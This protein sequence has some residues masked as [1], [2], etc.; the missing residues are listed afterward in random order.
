MKNTSHRKEIIIQEAAERTK[1]HERTTLSCRGIAREP[2]GDRDRDIHRDRETWHYYISPF[3]FD[4]CD[5]WLAS[6]DYHLRNISIIEKCT[7]AIRNQE[8][9]R[10]FA[11]AENLPEREQA[12]TFFQLLGTTARDPRVHPTAN[13]LQFHSIGRNVEHRTTG[14]LLKKHHKRNPT[15]PVQEQLC[16]KKMKGTSTKD[17]SFHRLTTRCPHLHHQHQQPTTKGL[18]TEGLRECSF[19]EQCAIA[20]RAQYLGL[21]P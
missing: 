21:N 3:L 11:I 5:L 7:T 18:K 12:R 1:Q 19:T 2:E 8:S 13:V 10:S 6:A 17:V 15:E 4:L 14:R 20:R 9:K 16:C